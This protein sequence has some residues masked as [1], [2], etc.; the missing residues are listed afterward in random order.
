MVDGA[1]H[2]PYGLWS[3]QCRIEKITVS[4]ITM[5]GLE[6][7]QVKHGHVS[8][9]DYLLPFQWIMLSLVGGNCKQ[10]FHWSDAFGKIVFPYNKF[11][12]Y[13]PNLGSER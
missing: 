7:I 6:H 10:L 2:A 1:F 5:P 9:E 4:P 13:I 8:T 11:Q 3:R 12:K